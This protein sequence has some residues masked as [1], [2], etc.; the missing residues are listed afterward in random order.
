MIKP[1]T[2]VLKTEFF[3]AL[4]IKQR[5]WERRREDL[6]CWL[7]LF[8]EYELIGKKPIQIEIKRV[9]KEYESLPRK[10]YDKIVSEE[11]EKDYEEFTYDALGEEFKPNSKSRVARNAIKSFG[12]KKYNHTSVEAV[13]KRYVKPAF[14][15]YGENDGNQIWVWY[16][17]YEEPDADV[18]ARWR[19]LLAEYKIDE[20]AAAKAFYKQQ[21]GEDISEEIGFY[22]QA[23]CAFKAEFGDILVLVKKW[24]RK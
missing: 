21:N 19:R 11:K 20:Q 12:L 22:K 13:A 18:V 7:N 17:T 1:G 15:K 5:Q 10:G 24:K 16:T 6:L 4:G 14:E 9:I 3:D 2:Y 8:F 23:Q